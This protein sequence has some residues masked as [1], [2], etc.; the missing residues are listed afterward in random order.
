MS[1]G[2]KRLIPIKLEFSASVSFIRK[3]LTMPLYFVY[4]ILLEDWICWTFNQREK[5]SPYEYIW[6]RSH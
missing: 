1:L 5:R 4:Q 2:F 6:Q 3:E